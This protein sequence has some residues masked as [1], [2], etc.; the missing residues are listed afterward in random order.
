MTDTQMTDIQM[1]IAELQEAL[2]TAHPQMPLLLRDIH[3]KLKADPAQVTL[4]TEEEIAVIVSG[5][6]LQTNVELASDKAKSGSTAAKTKSANSRL[7]AILKRANVS[8]DDF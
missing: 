4:L 2:L 6:K 5:L 1:K 3:K 8:A 7:N